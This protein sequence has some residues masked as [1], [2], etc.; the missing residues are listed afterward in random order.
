[1]LESIY[2]ELILDHYRKPRNKGVIDEPTVTIAMR[3]PFCGD[4]IELMV[5]IDGDE[6]SDVRFKGQGC[7]IS[8]ASASM[9]TVALKGHSLDEAVALEGLFLSLMR[10]EE[11]APDDRRLG[12]LRALEG[13]ARLPVRIKC[14]LLGWNALDEAVR[15]HRKSDRGLMNQRIEFQDM[16][17]EVPQAAPAP[18]GFDPA[19]AKEELPD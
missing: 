11:T 16:T 15:A 6:I 10:G 9:M 4:E 7:S 12:D 2:R 5:K 3:N 8:Q 19:R 14:A 1:M 18:A 17:A 13:V